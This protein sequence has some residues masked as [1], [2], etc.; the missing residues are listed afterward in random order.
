M[1]LECGLL[2]PSPAERPAGLG[3]MATPNHH[4]G[5]LLQWGGPPT[6]RVTGTYSKARVD[7]SM[8]QA[9]GCRKMHRKG[10]PLS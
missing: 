4:P 10:S 2:G 8:K 6:C 7:W 9:G 5:Q 3:V 1:G